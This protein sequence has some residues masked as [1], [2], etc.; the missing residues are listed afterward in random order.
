MVN[1]FILNW[2]LFYGF[3]LSLLIVFISYRFKSLNFSGSI[4]T[5]ILGTLV[6][7]VGGWLWA[8][9]ILTFFITSSALSKIGKSY[10]QKLQDTFE[11]SGTRDHWQVIANGGIGGILVLLAVFDPDK[12]EFYFWAYTISFAAATADTWATELGVVLKGKP[13]L[14]TT[15]KPVKPGVSGGV[16]V[17]GSVASFLGSFL[18]M[19][20]TSIF[21]HLST[22]KILVFTIFGFLG[23]LVDSFLGATIQGQYRCTVC[24]K[25]TEKKM[26]CDKETKLIK[27]HRWLNNDLVNLIAILASVLIYFLFS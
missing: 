10:K 11:K 5:L 15:L 26:H 22:E 18:I 25:Y 24:G 19:W 7:G 17:Y 9:P 13:V 6:F 23:S 16:S 27:G 1:G 14:I 8:I 2:Q 3:V 4:A 12:S 20:L 21:F